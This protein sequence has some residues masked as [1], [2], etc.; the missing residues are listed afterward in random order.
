MSQQ[1]DRL[2]LLDEAF[3]W[4][5]LSYIKPGTIH[6][7]SHHRELQYLLSLQNIFSSYYP[8]IQ[9]EAA[10]YR[11]GT[12]GIN[13]IKI[14]DM[15]YGSLKNLIEWTRWSSSYVIPMAISHA[16]NSYAYVLGTE[17]F[18]RIKNLI[19][20]VSVNKLGSYI[21]DSLKLTGS[22]EELEYL[23]ER[24]YTSA[25]LER[26]SISL[27][28]LTSILAERFPCYKAFV[29]RKTEDRVSRIIYD[30]NV[31]GNNLNSS[32]IK[33]Y[34]YLLQEFCKEPYTKA[35]KAAF[36][37]NGMRTAEGRK[38]LYNLDMDLRKRGKNLH[39][40][41]PALLNSVFSAMVRG[42]MPP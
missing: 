33:G 35:V 29:I 32:I 14:G 39:S 38:L 26:E 12:I 4:T 42:A 41:L 9:E 31:S 36:E 22:R 30:E 20:N 1:A 24:G 8:G 13:M 37:K 25:V 21:L 28:E 40:H 7:Y 27:Q 11:K 34:L 10:K 2:F 19:L 16:V 6:R 3:T 15:I 5:I 18:S 23:E 17:D